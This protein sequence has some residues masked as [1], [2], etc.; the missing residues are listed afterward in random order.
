MDV[1]D[2]PGKSSFKT[3]K[4]NYDNEIML[5]YTKNWRWQHSGIYSKTITNV[6]IEDI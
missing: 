5:T 3:S 4:L 1:Q 6:E 2:V